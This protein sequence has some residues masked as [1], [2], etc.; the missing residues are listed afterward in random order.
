[1]NCKGLEPLG[2]G[3]RVPEGVSAVNATDPTD[4]KGPTHSMVD[5]LPGIKKVEQMPWFW[6]RRFYSQTESVALVLVLSLV[7][8]S[9]IVL[10]EQVWN[11][12]NSIHSQVYNMC[13]M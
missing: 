2:E 10:R 3:A 1:M 12:T 9:M 8:D 4:H 11:Y 5:L 13:T 7:T 6:A